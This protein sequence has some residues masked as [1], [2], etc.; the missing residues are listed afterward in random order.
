[1]AI[2]AF[3]VAGLRAP[4][5]GVSL[6]TLFGCTAAVAAILSILTTAVLEKR[7]PSPQSG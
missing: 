2:L 4:A 1:M 3:A 7:S 5:A 6:P